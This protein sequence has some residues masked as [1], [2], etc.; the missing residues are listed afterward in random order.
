MKILFSL[1]TLVFL[2]KDC[3]N[4]SKSQEKNVV[5]NDLEIIYIANTRGFY[6]YLKI[7]QESVVFSKDRDLKTT[8]T[9]DCPEKDWKTLVKLLSEVDIKL[10]NT[11]EP[12]SKKFQFDGAPMA[13]LELKT[14]EQQVKTPIFDHGNPPKEIVK[15]VTK[16]LGLK[17]KVLSN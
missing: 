14:N 13:T 17:D 16:V 2:A 10:V 12:P 4:N 15:V 5:Q 1:L 11:L 8:I 6:E 7:T 9:K 3:K